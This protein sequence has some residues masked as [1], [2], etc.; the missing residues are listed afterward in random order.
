MSTENNER[1]K[2][3]RIESEDKTLL[4]RDTESL[5]SDSPPTNEYENEPTRRFVAPIDENAQTTLQ[6]A[7]DTEPTEIFSDNETDKEADE[8]KNVPDGNALP[9]NRLRFSLVCL[10]FVNMFIFAGINIY[11]AFLIQSVPPFVTAP[12]GNGFVIVNVRQ[13]FE[14]AFQV[15][16]EMVSVN[17]IEVNPTNIRQLDNLA[18][19]NPGERRIIVVRRNG[20]M[21][22]VETVSVSP[23]LSF[24]LN[25]VFYDGLLRAIFLITGLLIFLFKPNDK[26]ALLLTLIFGSS[27][28]SGSLS[29]LADLPPILLV[30]KVIGFLNIA[31]CAPLF[32]HFCLVFPERSS[33]LRRIPKLEY[34]IYLPI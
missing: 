11:Q 29:A 33:L 12:Q 30:V 6:N 5:S 16:D 10:L 3:S 7:P 21:R 31:F 24:R 20:E 27:L 1:D 18:L 2:V 22:E 14:G 28:A 17:G 26:Q 8:R 23:P 13:G 34:L 4:R 25:R 15:G 32:L 9:P 19:N